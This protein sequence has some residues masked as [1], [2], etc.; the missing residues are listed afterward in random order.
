MIFIY[1]T[2]KYCTIEIERNLHLR[3]CNNKKTTFKSLPKRGPCCSYSNCGN[4][5]FMQTTNSTL[6]EPDQENKIHR[7]FTTH[8]NM[9]QY[10]TTARSVQTKLLRSYA[11]SHSCQETNTKYYRASWPARRLYGGG[12]GG[13]RS[14]YKL[15]A[16]EHSYGQ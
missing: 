15:W 13:L 2:A 9:F 3:Q 6:E 14:Q 7:S 4:L 16:S 5:T 8:Y 11:I 10:D 1:R 12:G